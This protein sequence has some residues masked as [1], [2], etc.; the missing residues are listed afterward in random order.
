MKQLPPQLRRRP[1]DIDVWSQS[2][3]VSSTRLEEELEET[4]K[5]DTFK[6]RVLPM[7]G[8]EGQNVYKIVRKEYGK[9]RDIADYMK[10]PK[11]VGP[12]DWA[13]IDG[14]KYEAVEHAK[15][16]KIENL[17]SPEKKYRWSKEAEELR[18][19]EAYERGVSRGLSELTGR[20]VF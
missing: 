1:H 17:Q 15:K 12:S 10:V 20:T 9:D 11:D 18:R 3:K 2:P 4:T 16:K 19:I 7:I 8:P 14:I 6:K 5:G 13:E